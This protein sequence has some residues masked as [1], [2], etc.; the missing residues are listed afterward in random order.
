VNEDISNNYGNSKFGNKLGANNNVNN[1]SKSLHQEIKEE[2]YRIPEG[3][4]FCESLLLSNNSHKALEAV[5]LED[6]N[7]FYLEKDDFDLTF[8]VN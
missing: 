2:I 6:S 8:S 5:A 1:T 4:C 3:F 7:I